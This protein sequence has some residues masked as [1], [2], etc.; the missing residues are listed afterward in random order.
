MCLLQS[1]ENFSISLNSILGG[2]L[3]VEMKF[4]GSIFFLQVNADSCLVN[5][6]YINIAMSGCIIEPQ[7]LINHDLFCFRI[8]YPDLIKSL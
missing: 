8:Y 2:N 6:R 5:P 7:V 4:Y 1:L 3:V